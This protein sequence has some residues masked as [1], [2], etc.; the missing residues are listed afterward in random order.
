[1][2]YPFATINEV[3]LTPE[4]VIA[5]RTALRDEGAFR[6]EQL[7]GLAETWPLDTAQPHT[8]HATAREEVLHALAEAAQNVLTDVEAALH[9]LETGHYGSCHLC[10]RPIPLPRLRILPHARYCGPC[11]QLKE[12]LA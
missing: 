10:D 3:E 5:L 7:A 1:M 6:R 2:S 9:R 11:H 4:D 8:P 12:T